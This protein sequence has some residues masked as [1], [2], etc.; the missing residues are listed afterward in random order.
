MQKRVTPPYVPESESV[1]DTTHIDEEFL[2]ESISETPAMDCELT[3]MH[4][5]DGAFGNFDYV[6][7]AFNISQLEGSNDFGKPSFS[8]N[9]DIDN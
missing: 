3:K 7:E 5:K 8:S 4:N 6:S 9:D 1:E 2:R